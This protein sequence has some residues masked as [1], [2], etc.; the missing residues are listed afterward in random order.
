M[1]EA[2]RTL[3]EQLARLST[4][5]PGDAALQ[6][7][8]DTVAVLVRTTV[9]G[10]DGVS[11]SI[12]VDDGFVT[13]S[14]TDEVVS[15]LDGVQYRHRSG[16]CVEAIATG[17]PVH[18][19]LLAEEERFPDF[20]AA[21]QQRFMT[22]VHSTPLEAGS[23]AVGALNIYSASSEELTPEAADM[24]ADFARHAAVLLVHAATLA[25]A[26][27]AN[28]QLQQALQ[29]RDVIGQ[30]KGILMARLGCSADDA[31]DVL[32]RASQRENRKLNAIAAELVAEQ[33][34]RSRP[35]GPA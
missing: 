35:E 14:A 21:A 29:N 8:L 4:D 22:A 13:A 28:E 33:G 32:R 16:P 27:T 23:R 19:S 31:F 26:A 24:A 15:E 18:V 20:V 30:A 2:D 9:P 5:V 25:T 34:R 7:P 11:V 1:S 10:A 6:A 3:S 17:A 12:P